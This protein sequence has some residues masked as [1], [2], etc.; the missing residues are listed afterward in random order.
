[1]DQTDYR[2]LNI[3]QN[4]CRV[5]LKS[6]GGDVGL[7]APAVSERIHKMEETGVIQGFRIDIDRNRLDCNIT[8]FIFA[9]PK[10]EKYRQFCHF[11]EVTPAIIAHHHLIGEFNALLRFAVQ[12]TKELDQILAAIKQYGNS[13]TTVELNT[14]F[15]RKDIPLPE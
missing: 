14:Y 12:N 8:G 5:T 7:T 2:I 11:C 9:A 1:M 4:D 10:P 3:L 6:I 13:Q 15:Q